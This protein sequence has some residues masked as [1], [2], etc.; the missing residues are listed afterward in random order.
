MLIC[1]F[2]KKLETSTENAESGTIEEI[3]EHIN[4]RKPVMI[5]FKNYDYKGIT[6]K[7]KQ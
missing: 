6:S 7:N 3:N 5:Y 4:E 2:G 1:V